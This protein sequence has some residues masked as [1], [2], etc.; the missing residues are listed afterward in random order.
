MRNQKDEQKQREIDQLKLEIELLHKQIQE[1][2][3]T[4]Y[5]EEN[6]GTSVVSIYTSSCLVF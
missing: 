5:R 4:G 2:S 3:D 1:K 6:I